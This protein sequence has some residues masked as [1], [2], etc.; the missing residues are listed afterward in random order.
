MSNFLSTKKFGPI[1]TSHRNWAAATNPNRDSVKC[2]WCH[3]YSRYVEFTFEG[4]LDRHQWVYDF[5]DCKFIKAWLEENWDHKTL[6]SALDP[7]L[8]FLM[9]ADVRNVLKLTIIPA[10]PGWGPGMEGSAKWI[11]DEINPQILA[12]TEGRVSIQKVQIWE[13]EN[14]SAIYMAPTK[15]NDE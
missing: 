6:V 12:K 2:S 5:G 14:N 3:G 10:K 13:H 7:E 8:P 4:T 1:S 11:F 9:E 15:E